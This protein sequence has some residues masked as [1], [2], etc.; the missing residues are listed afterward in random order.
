MQL[1]LRLGTF[2]TVLFLVPMFVTSQV[3]FLETF[4][5]ANGATTGTASGLDWSADCPMCLS[6]DYWEVQNGVLEGNDTNGEAEWLNDDLI[7]VS[8]CGFVEVSFDIQSVGNMEACGTGCNSADWVRFQ[9]NVDGA[10]W[11]DPPNSYFCSGPCS[12]INVVVDGDYTGTYNSGCLPVNGNNLQIRISVQCWAGSESWQIDN[13]S[14]SCGGA[15]AGGDGSLSL[16]EAGNSV[17]LLNELTGNPDSGGTWTGPSNLLGGDLGTFDPSSMVAGQYTYTVGAGSC[18]NSANV[19]VTIL[20]TPSVTVG[21]DTVICEGSSLTL[22]ASGATSYSWSNGLGNGGTVVISPNTTTTYS[23]EGTD[24]NGCTSSDDILVTVNQLPTPVITG[25]TTYCSGSFAVLS[26]ASPYSSY[27]WSNGV[28]TA[29]A[30]VNAANNP[31]SVTVTDAAGCSGT[32][33]DISV[34][35]TPLINHDSI[36]EICQGQSV[37]IH[38]TVET[39][40]GVYSQTFPSASGCD[41]TSN[42]TLLVKATPS[43]NAGTDQTVCNDGTQFTLNGSGATN[44]SWN[45]GVQD[46]VPFTPTLGVTTYEVST[47][48]QNGCVGTDQVNVTVNPLP[49]VDAGADQTLCLG[50]FITLSGTGATSYVWDNGV[51]NGVSFSPVLSNTYT[52]VGTDVNGCV[53][54][55]SIFI[56]VEEAPSI[57]FEGDVLSGCA[58]LEVN[59]TNNSVGNFANATWMFGNGEVVSTLGNT[60]SSFTNSG[61]YDVTLSLTTSGGC[62]VTKTYA[63]YIVVDNTPSASFLTS[64]T[65]LNSFNSTVNFNNTSIGGV[66][67]SWDFGDGTQSNVE[68]PVHTY[69]V[70]ISSNYTVELIAESEVGC[71]DTATMELTTGGELIYYIPNAFTPDGDEFN[72]T[73]QPVFTEGFDPFDYTLL[74]FNR[75]GEVVFESHDVTIG[76]DGTYP[77]STGLNAGVYTWKVEFKTMASDERIVDTGH[78]NVLR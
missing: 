37:I 41:S 39:T 53:G 35:E 72:Q 68:D 6:G 38:G 57:V 46:G 45:N 14:V 18:T 9:Y 12:G 34:V 31:I 15:N 44:F 19:D 58:P 73:F 77:N 60:S 74:I 32:S 63:N 30:N 75:W 22:N 54:T 4:D 47:T 42:V 8:T 2:L 40:A 78:V 65:S 62:V 24:A 16:C 3:L 25:A 76:W 5:E 64:S 48:G 7:D 1:L 49:T 43:I 50:D 29:T 59:F 69:E 66:N 52:V 13:V 71:T 33:A 70:G 11:M 36:V 21:V 51:T 17:N 56:L 26:V 61:T 20:P 23:V 55:D 27:S 67:Y 10:G 28:T